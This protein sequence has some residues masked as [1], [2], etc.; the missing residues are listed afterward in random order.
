[1]RLSGL[2][3]WQVCP[4]EWGPQIVSTTGRP[5]LSTRLM[6]SLLYL[7]HIYALSNEDTVER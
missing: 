1:M 2:I 4:D 6:A 5:S 3:D 7:K